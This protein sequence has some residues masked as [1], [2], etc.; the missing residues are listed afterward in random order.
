MRLTS[1]WMPGKARAALVAGTP[2]FA[3]TTVIVRVVFPIV[4]VEV[5]MTLQ[6]ASS[7]AVPAT[8]AQGP[9]V[10]SRP[11]PVS[12]SSPA[13]QSLRILTVKVPCTRP[14]PGRLEFAAPRT[15]P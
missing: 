13:L 3:T 15:A 2:V 8:S 6:L 4:P 10:V 12:L 11:M 9:V 1:A 14:S 7:V 5:T